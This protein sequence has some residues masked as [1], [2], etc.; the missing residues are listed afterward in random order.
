MSYI[1]NSDIE[2][3]LGTARYVQLTDDAGTGSANT[4]V[5]DEVRLGAEGEVDSYLAQR[6]AVPI[7]LTAHAELAAPLASATL[8]LAEYRLFARRRAVPVD[9]IGKRD[10]TLAWLGRVARG[11]VSLPSLT[12]LASNPASGIRAAAVGEERTLSR[13]ELAGF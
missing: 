5:A 7:D 9:V 1:A 4:A 10:A 3:R 8:D 13:E 6:H 11:E 12:E 2:L